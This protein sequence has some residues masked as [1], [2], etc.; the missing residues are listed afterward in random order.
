MNYLKE[1]VEGAPSR[2]IH[3]VILFWTLVVHTSLV[4]AVLHVLKKTFGII[5]TLGSH[6]EELMRRF[7]NIYKML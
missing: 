3:F 6:L 7:L 2:S 1:Q 5:C 4:Y